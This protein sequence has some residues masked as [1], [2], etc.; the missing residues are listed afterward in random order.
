MQEEVRGQ[1]EEGD[2]KSLKLSR[3]AWKALRPVI[4]SMLPCRKKKKK[5][6][7]RVGPSSSTTHLHVYGAAHNSGALGLSAPAVRTE[8]LLSGPAD[9]SAAK[10]RHLPLPEGGGRAG[11]GWEEPGVTE[12]SV[13]EGAAGLGLAG[14]GRLWTRRGVPSIIWCPASCRRDY[15]LLART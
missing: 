7:K 1:W 12:F 6:L 2:Y 8:R 9:V 13:P 10:L 3:F 11:Q 5:K 4:C 15:Y 14:L